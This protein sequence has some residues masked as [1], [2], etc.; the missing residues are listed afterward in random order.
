MGCRVEPT[1]VMFGVA[2]PSQAFCEIRWVNKYGSNGESSRCQQVPLESLR[3]LNQSS[4]HGLHFA[5]LP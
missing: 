5:R 4:C 2:F 3:R 1:Y